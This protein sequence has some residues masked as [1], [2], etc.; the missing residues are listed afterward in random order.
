M[1][2]QNLGLAALL[3]SISTVTSRLRLGGCPQWACGTICRSTPLDDYKG[4]HGRAKVES[5]QS[6][7]SSYC[8][9]VWPRTA[10]RV[11]PTE[12]PYMETVMMTHAPTR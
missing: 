3:P 9:A 8:F 12:Y 11:A 10:E 6:M 4:I 5:E 1:L 2:L 7:S